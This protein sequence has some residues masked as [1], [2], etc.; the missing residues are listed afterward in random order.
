MKNKQT[1]TKFKS[2]LRDAHHLFGWVVSL[3]AVILICSGASAQNLF[4]S[5][6][7]SGIARNLGHIYKFTPQGAQSSL[8]SGLNGPLGLAFDSAGNLFVAGFSGNIDRFTPAGARSTFASGLTAPEGL[9]F[10]SEDNLFVSD[11]GYIYEFTPGGL[12]STFASGLNQAVGLAFDRAG[13]L[14]VADLR[15][16][17]I[18]KFTPDGIRTTF[19]FGLNQPFDLAFDGAG[20]LFVTDWGIWGMVNGIWGSRGGAIYKFTPGG[21]R[22]TFAEL[23]APEGLAFDS[24]GNLFVVDEDTGNIFKF[25]PAGVRSTF[26]KAVGLALDEVAFLAFDPTSAPPASELSNISTRG[27]V[28]TG[29]NALIAGFIVTGSDP[30]PVIARGLGPSLSRFGVSNALQDPVLELRNS[31]SILNLNDD[32]PTA[33]APAQ[34][35]TNYRPTDMRESAFMTTLPPGAYTTVLS[36]KNGTTGNGLL[37]IYSTLS[38]PSNFSTRGFC[39]TGDHVLIG[40]F[41]SSGGN[42]SLQVII[43]ALG[44]TLTQFGVSGAL[45]DPTLT[46]LDSNGNVVASNDNWKNTQQT[47][48]Q[49]SGFAPP[50][51]LESAILTTLPNGNYTALL[52]GKNGG[53][54]VGLLEIYKVAVATNQ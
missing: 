32:W 50:N 42:G 8:A 54:G 53:T 10:D 3:G 25:T 18:Y 5:D 6:G 23:V 27:F 44:P 20:N 36:G 21:V 14:F 11:I 24:A 40:G 31:T 45:S 38:G 51:D 28:Q 35:P 39:G 13:N 12:R 33:A 17:A 34:V 7:Y 26:A 30:Q 43:R 16:G 9:A 15:A 49:N 29:E 4:M 41:M 22:S 37:E 19:A 52:V 47:A 46:L 48:I 2:A 1:E